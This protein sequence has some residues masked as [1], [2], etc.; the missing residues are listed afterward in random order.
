VRVAEPFVAR[1]VPAHVPL[2]LVVDFDLYDPPG[3]DSDFHGAWKALQDRA[4]DIVWTTANGGHWIALR[5]K[6][7]HK[8]FA[9]YEHFSSR[10]IIVPRER[11]DKIKVKPTTLDPPVHGPYRA[12]LNAGLSQKAVREMEPEIRALVVKT[13][14]SFYARGQCEFISEFAEILPISIFMRMV[15]LPVDDVRFLKPWADQINRPD[16]SMEPDEVMR[17]F[18]DYLRPFVRARHDKPGADLL[19]QI[20]TGLVNGAPLAEGDAIELCTQVLIGGMDTVVSFMGFMMI[21]LAR[22]PA[23][24]RQLLEEP[25]LIRPAVDEF[26]RR[27]PIVQNGRLVVSDYEFSGVTMKA[28]DVV[29]M[30]GVLHGLDEREYAN[31]L[32]VDFHRKKG[33]HSTFG[34]GAHHCPG[35][36][37][38]RAELRIT[39][40][41]WLARIPNFQIMPGQQPVTQGGIVGCVQ[42]L[43]L[44]WDVADNAGM[45]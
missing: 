41:E 34:N 40:E 37:L 28:G 1:N 10:V 7:I 15:N 33:A 3:A 17:R 24:R 14:E 4:P 29:I 12:L 8:I 32:A 22:N 25:G 38:A 42:K 36:T 21:F 43:P 26:L 13:I 2:D 18:A 11:G 45:G 19:S 5:G 9:D 16:G 20:V 31:P 27:F 23:H 6:Q 44:Q 39:L 35:A 30:P